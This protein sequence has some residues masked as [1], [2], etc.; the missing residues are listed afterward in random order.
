MRLFEIGPGKHFLCGL[1][2][3]ISISPKVPASVTASKDSIEAVRKW[4]RTSSPGAADRPGDGYSLT[5]YWLCKMYDALYY[6]SCLLVKDSIYVIHIL[7][8]S[9]ADDTTVTMRAPGEFDFRGP[10]RSFG[11]NKD[12]SAGAIGP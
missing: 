4:L 10:H 5:S 1:P 9:I 2:G 8:A 11:D 7:H 6:V 12:F 3:Y